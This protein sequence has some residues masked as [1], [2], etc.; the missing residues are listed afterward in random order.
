MQ[1]FRVK[2]ATI[3]DIHHVAELF[4]EYRVFYS[5]SSDLDGAKRY[6][7][8]RFEH[9]DSVIFAASHQDSQHM[10]GFAQLYPTFS[11][12]SMQR[13]WILND[14]YVNERFRQL[15][16]AQLLLDSIKSYAIQTKAKGIELST[17]FDNFSAQRLYERN[18]FKKVEQYINYFL[19][20]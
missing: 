9:R 12:I 5:Q 17:A 1:S 14:L 16:V 7:F 19:E 10:A 15:G 2:Q 3:D 13:S 18:D 11:S 4:N 20:F 8:E 6:L